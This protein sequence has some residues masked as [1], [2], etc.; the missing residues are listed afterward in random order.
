MV[1][2]VAADKMTLGKEIRALA[3]SE[4]ELQLK[5]FG[6]MGFTV[7]SGFFSQLHVEK[8]RRRITSGMVNNKQ[9]I[10]KIMR[11]VT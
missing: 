2:F 9:K 7:G 4:S 5:V 3:L 6:K 8:R 1:R 11:K 10:I